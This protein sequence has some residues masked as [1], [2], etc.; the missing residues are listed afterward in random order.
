MENENTVPVSGVVFSS[1][2]GSPVKEFVKN[3]K[4]NHFCEKNVTNR[5][6]KRRKR[7]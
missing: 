6:N 2:T 7:V 3:P 1:G 4:T 5:Y